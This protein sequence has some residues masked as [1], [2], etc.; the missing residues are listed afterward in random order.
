MLKLI[1][2]M[3]RKNPGHEIKAVLNFTERKSNKE[4]RESVQELSEKLQEIIPTSFRAK[5]V[6][7]PAGLTMTV[8]TSK[9]NEA[10]SMQGK[11]AGY[12]KTAATSLSLKT[13]GG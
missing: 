1:V 7:N 8:R 6:E 2:S 5:F 13:S 11:V 3:H 4:M 10:Q 12:I 9:L